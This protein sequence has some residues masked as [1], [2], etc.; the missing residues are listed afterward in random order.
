MRLRLTPN[1]AT[2]FQNRYEGSIPRTQ[3]Y[4]TRKKRL[5]ISNEDGGRPHRRRRGRNSKLTIAP[6]KYPRLSLLPIVVRI[7]C[8][9][10]IGQYYLTVSPEEA[11][12]YFTF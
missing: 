8:P 11:R 6:R 10:G 3:L 12:R 5:C 9:G 7:L 4:L 1:M 2:R